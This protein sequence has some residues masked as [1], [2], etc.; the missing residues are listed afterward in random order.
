MN[1][2][3]GLSDTNIASSGIPLFYRLRAGNIEYLPTPGASGYTS[4]L[5]YVP[6]P[7]TLASGGATTFDTID[8]LDDYI[9]WYAAREVAKKDRL[10]DLHNVLSQN[11]AELRSD[12]EML[13][14]NRDMNSPPRV[15]DDL[16]CDRFGRSGERD[17][18][19]RRLR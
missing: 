14:R 2:R 3:P 11:L 13:A 4:T 7:V 6:V 15:R 8:R 16:A 19:G 18:Y 17:R 9:I 5:W 10:W 12:I 1:D